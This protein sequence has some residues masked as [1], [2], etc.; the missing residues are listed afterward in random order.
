MAN[1]YVECTEGSG[2]KLQTHKNTIGANDVHAEAVV[3]VDD[4]G[5]SIGP[6]KEAGGNLATIAGDTTSLDGKVTAC[7]TGAVT[8]SAALPAGANAI[9]KLAANSGVDI[10]D[11]DVTSVVPGT[12]AANLGKAEDAAHTSGDVGVMMLAVRNDT[13]TSLAS[14]DQEYV[15]VA[16]DEYGRLKL[17]TD[18][19]VTYTSGN[20]DA[21]ADGN[22]I[23]AGGAGVVTKIHMLSIQAQGTVTVNI[24]DGDGGASLMEWKLEDR[25]GAVYP[26][27]PAPAQITKSSA[28]TALYVNLSAAV[29]VTINYTYSQA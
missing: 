19:G 17:S 6:A 14:V 12:A 11:T 8:I 16:A 13:P 1:D 21:A 10:G 26:W 22:L 7:N 3:V 27:V 25:E 9:G 24:E 2:K 29:T 15:P 18:K 23:A 20:F 5:A 28:N 4:A